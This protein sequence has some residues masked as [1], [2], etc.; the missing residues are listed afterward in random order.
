MARRIAKHIKKA[1]ADPKADQRMTNR[2]YVGAT[3]MAPG[4]AK[5]TKRAAE[6]HAEKLLAENSTLE[7][8]FIVRV[9]ARVRR[10][11][12]PVVVEKL[13]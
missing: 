13:D 1:V 7:Q 3:S 8:V 9:V 10:K 2:Y 6:K 11:V 12:A 4:W 5:P